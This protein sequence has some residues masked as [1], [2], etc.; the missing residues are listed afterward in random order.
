MDYK[1]H[2]ASAL[3]THPDDPVSVPV[4]KR[5][6]DWA[7]IL[8]TIPIW[9]PVMLLIG[10][11]IKFF[12]RGPI[13]FKQ[14]RV[15]LNR[16]RFTCL[17]FRTMK[18]NADSA[19]HQRHLKSLMQSQV[20]MTKLDAA[21]DPRLI[22]GGML[23]RATGLDELPQLFNVLRGE[24]SLVGPRPCTLYEYDGFLP[25][26][27]ERFQTLPGL[28]GLWQVSGKNKT[29]FDE[30]MHL[31]IDYARQKSLWL[32]LR[33]LVKTLPAMIGQVREA[34]RWKKSSKVLSPEQFKSKTPELEEY[35]ASAKWPCAS[36]Q[37]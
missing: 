23:L 10:L 14:E 11:G 5:S 36:N 17:K 26:H 37:V 29:T 16:Q 13:L 1:E 30:M 9:A 21:G 4:W 34:R 18:V 24:M 27:L 7:L 33:I 35:E 2:G 6:L 12:S 19:G 31:D 22:P 8:L 15:G 20:P 32:D 3:G 25:W 28:T